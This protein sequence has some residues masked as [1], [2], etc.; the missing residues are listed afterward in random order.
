MSETRIRVAAAGDVHCDELGRERAQAAFARVARESDLVLLAGDLT[1]HGEPAEAA[2]LADACRNL[3]IPVVAVLGNHDLHAGHHDEVVAV[4]R[5]AGITL[6][7][8]GWTVCDVNGATVG[9]VGTKG[10]VGGF[11]GSSIPDFGEPSLRGLY[12][13]TTAEVEAIDRGLE[14]VRD[15]SLRIVLLHYAP[16]MTTLAGEPEGIWA[17]LGS[18]RLAAPIARH[19]ADLVVHGHAHEGTF[20]GAIGAVPVYNVAVQVTGRDF[21][22]FEL[23]PGATRPDVGVRATPT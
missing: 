11:P 6:L 20:E 16:T 21:W 14:A 2:V 12:A 7:E 8:Q 3:P 15:C 10:F 4:L 9:V 18:N 22:I 5:E 23:E 19:R 1:T 13:E 17:L